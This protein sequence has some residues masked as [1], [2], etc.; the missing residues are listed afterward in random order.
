MH[1]A[2]LQ[3]DDCVCADAFH[4]VELQ[5]SLKISSIESGDGQAVTKSSLD[6][7]RGRRSDFTG[8]D[9]QVAFY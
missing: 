4:G 6:T 3:V 2:D 1:D 9:D 7:S 8:L 5:I